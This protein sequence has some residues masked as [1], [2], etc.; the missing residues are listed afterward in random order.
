MAD[1]RPNHTLYIKNLNQKIAKDELKKQLYYL[2]S[3]YGPIMDIVAMRTEKMRGQA[4]VV[5]SEI[6][7]ATKALRALQGFPFLDQQL[8]CQYAKTDSEVIVAKKGATGKKVDKK[9][10]AAKKKPTSAG[11]SGPLIVQEG[12][13]AD[14][15]L[16]IT[17]L[18]EEANEV[19]ITMLFQ[20][21]TGFVTTR[22]LPGKRG[23]A[24]V[25]F[26]NENNASLA[27]DSLQGFKIS[28]TNAMKI[29]F[30]SK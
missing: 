24:F 23:M 4:F 16:F 12:E 30:A 28:P 22:I 10:Q 11:T 2:F 26:D 27:K 18:P 20:Q 7:D 25:D 21:F 14:K 13:V 17:N 19:M 3:Q 1:I 9:K 15:V 29:T 6:P 5:F 8:R